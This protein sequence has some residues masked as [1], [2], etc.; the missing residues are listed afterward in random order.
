MK[1]RDGAAL[2]SDIKLYGLDDKR[3]GEM[4]LHEVEL[5]AD[6]LSK[7]SKGDVAPHFYGEDLII[8]FGAPLEFRWW[9]RKNMTDKD[10]YSLFLSL[11]VPEDKLTRYM[12][13][14]D[15]DCALGRCDDSG[16]PTTTNPRIRG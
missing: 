2:W 8:R 11:G 5:L 9:E 7:H 1:I 12:S 10:R 4:S 14:R 13:Q 15:I 6:L 16:R 3:L